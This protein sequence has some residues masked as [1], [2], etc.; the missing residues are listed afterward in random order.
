MR[1]A[2]GMLTSGSENRSFGAGADGYVS[3]NFMKLFN[4]FLLTNVFLHIR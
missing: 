3:L 1:E 4:L 2:A